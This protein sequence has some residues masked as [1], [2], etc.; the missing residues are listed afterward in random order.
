MTL[1]PSIGLPR[2]SIRAYKTA[3]RVRSGRPL[4]RKGLYPLR[5]HY[6]SSLPL[7]GYEAGLAAIPV[8]RA[9]LPIEEGHDLHSAL[10]GERG[11]EH[12]NLSVSIHH[13][14]G[15]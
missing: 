6:R 12:C 15:S 1:T 5:T 2:A 8:A 7:R 11:D 14:G 3:A 9:H 10:L 13:V 4:K